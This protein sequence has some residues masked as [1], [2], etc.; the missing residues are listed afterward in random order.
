MLCLAILVWRIYFRKTGDHFSGKCAKGGS[1][2]DVMLTVAL[3]AACMVN[4]ACLF[5][6]L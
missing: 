2:M 6:H 5:G 3:M 4:V 1:A